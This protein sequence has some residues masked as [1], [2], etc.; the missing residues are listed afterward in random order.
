[1]IT[2]RSLNCPT[3]GTNVAAVT[4][5]A[6]AILPLANIVAAAP[7]TTPPLAVTIPASAALPFE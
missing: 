7:T 5:P 1:M 3:V 4:I 6:A 2:L